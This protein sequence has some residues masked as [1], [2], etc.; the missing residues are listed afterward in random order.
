MTEVKENSLLFVYGTLRKG[1]N[2]HG[3]IEDKPFITEAVIEGSLILEG[4]LPMVFPGPGLVVGEIYQI[5]DVDS[6]RR[7][8][9]LE[10]HPGWYNRREVDATDADGKAYRVWVY[11]MGTPEESETELARALRNGGR[12]VEHGN[13]KL[14]VSR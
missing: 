3:L 6:W 12:V 9:R 1:F 14:A 2:N 7:L 13:Y 4:W 8:D 10:G 11:F 5:D